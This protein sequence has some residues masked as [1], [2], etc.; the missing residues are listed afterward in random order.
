MIG[1]LKVAYSSS[2][3]QALPSEQPADDVV[4]GSLICAAELRYD[5]T[6]AGWRA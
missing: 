5:S 6:L 4:N 1:M 2:Q 3:A